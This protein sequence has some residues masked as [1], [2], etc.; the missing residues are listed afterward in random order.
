MKK[1]DKW[2]TKEEMSDLTNYTADEQYL[3]TPLVGKYDTGP[4]K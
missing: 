3:V 2:R 1:V 4:E